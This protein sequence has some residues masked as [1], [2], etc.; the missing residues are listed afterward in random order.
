[1][2]ATSAPAINAGANEMATIEKAIEATI[3]QRGFNEPINDT[4]CLSSV[5]NNIKRFGHTSP[6]SL[7]DHFLAVCHIN[8]WDPARVSFAQYRELK[9]TWNSRN[10]DIEFKISDYLVGAPEDV[11]RSLAWYLLSRAHGRECLNSEEKPYL[12]YVRSNELWSEKRETYLSRAKNL[13]IVPRGDVRDLES[14]FEYVNSCYFSGRLEDPEL[15]WVDESPL[16]RFGFYFGPLNLLAAN[17]ILD[18]ERVPRYVLEFVM[19]HELLHHVDAGNGRTRRRVHHTT[20]FRKQEKAFSHYE[21][22]ERWLRKLVSET[23][24]KRT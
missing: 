15:A 16:S 2:G 3:R 20:E 8:G 13:S 23:R 17:K 7:E 1:M 5:A 24:R 4:P 14:V 21:D 11:Q 18:S 9:H 6:V 22:A 12:E 10:G 19:Y